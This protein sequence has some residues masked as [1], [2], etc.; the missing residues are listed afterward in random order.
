MLW[1]RH[2]SF[3]IRAKLINITLHHN[4][5]KEVPPCVNIHRD[6]DADFMF[7]FLSSVSFLLLSKVWMINQ[8]AR[9]MY[10]FIKE[11]N[12]N[13]GVPFLSLFSYRKNKQMENTIW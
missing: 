7:L 2:A 8:A 4:E 11:R 6:A 5:W 9:V 1:I 3:N 13:I 12:Q 10:K